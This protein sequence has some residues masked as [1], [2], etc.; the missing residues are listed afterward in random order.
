VE[1]VRKK[2]SYCKKDL[3]IRRVVDDESGE[4]MEPMEEVPLI[5]L[6]ESETE[7]LL[8]GEPPCSD[9]KLTKMIW[10]N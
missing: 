5:R 9:G 2:K 8:C 10:L 3:Q 7:R 6:G 4:W 1:S